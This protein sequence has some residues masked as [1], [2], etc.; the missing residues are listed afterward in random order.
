MSIDFF[1]V[2][3]GLTKK[4]TECVYPG[5]ISPEASFCNNWNMRTKNLF[6]MLVNLKKEPIEDWNVNFILF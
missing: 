2:T 6:R 4:V 1:D 5:L 3:K